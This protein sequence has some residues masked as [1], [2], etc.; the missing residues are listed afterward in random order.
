[1]AEGDGGAETFTQEQMDAAVEAGK[2]GLVA[3]QTALMDETKEAKRALAAFDGFD[4]N[5]YKRLQDAEA[6]AAR[7]KAEGEGDW[8]KLEENLVTAHGLELQSEKDRTAK[9][10]QS[11]DDSLVVAELTRAIA[12][13]KGDVKLLL[14]HARK[15]V[16]TRETDDGFEAFVVDEKGTPAFSDGQG[17]PMTFDQLVETRLTVDFPRAFE[18]TGSSGGGASR[19]SAGGQGRIAGTIAAEDGDS[20]MDNLEGVASGKVQVR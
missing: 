1:M 4:A 14:P 6:E 17:T 11:V 13:A 18:G 2:A 12:A 19:S 20:F 15:Y 3:N 8:T 9:A 16:H 5:E 10:M 7:K